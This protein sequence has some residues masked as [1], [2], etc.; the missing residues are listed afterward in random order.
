[1]L[2]RPDG[3]IGWAGPGDP[4]RLL[5]GVARWCGPADAGRLSGSQ[6]MP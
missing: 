3:Y 6:P 4:R 5:R 2:I 1:M